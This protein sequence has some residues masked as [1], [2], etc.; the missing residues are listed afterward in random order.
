MMPQKKTISAKQAKAA[1]AEVYGDEAA[2]ANLK[3]KLDELKKQKDEYGMPEE[4]YQQRM[5]QAY[6]EYDNER[7]ATP[8]KKKKEE[9]AGPSGVSSKKKRRKKAKKKEENDSED[10]D[11]EEDDSEEED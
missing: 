3:R 2:I 9:E 5:R 8:V 1:V 4:Y 6:D 10:D 11:S 7:K